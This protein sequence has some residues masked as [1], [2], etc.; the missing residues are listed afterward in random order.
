MPSIRTSVRSSYSARSRC[1]VSKPAVR[2]QVERYTV[3]ASLEWSATTA[4]AVSTGSVARLSGR[5][6]GVGESGSAL[7]AS[8]IRCTAAFYRNVGHR[9]RWLAW[10]GIR[11]PDGA[12]DR[13]HRARRARHGRLA[14]PRARRRAHARARRR[15]RRDRGHPRRVGHERR[16]GVRAARA[17]RG[18][19]GDGAHR[20]DRRG[21]PGPRPQGAR[22]ALRRDRPE[23]G[24]R[25]RRA[26]RRG[27]R[28]RGHP[29]QQ[30][31][32]PRPRRSVPRPAAR[33]LGARPPRQ[34]DRRLQLLAGGRGR[35]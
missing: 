23:H 18:R 24:R 19:A 33:P 14:R 31:R 5:A 3:A 20:G 28:R 26:R 16:G 30:R 11:S 6:D 29:R 12:R 34:P 8:S 22:G 32:H 21:D 35:T 1:T 13:P 10:R 27:A 9:Q 15:R 7:G 4:F 25:G 17:G 2:A